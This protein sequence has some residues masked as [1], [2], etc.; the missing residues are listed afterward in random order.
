MLVFKQVTNQE[1]SF[2]ILIQVLLRIDQYYCR[3]SV[4]E[5]SRCFYK[6]SFRGYFMSVTQN[7]HRFVRTIKTIKIFEGFPVLRS[8]VMY[9]LCML[10]R[11]CWLFVN[12][13]QASFSCFVLSKELSWNTVLP[14]MIVSGD[15]TTSKVITVGRT[16]RLNLN[17]F[18][19]S[20]SISKRNASVS[21]GVR[22]TEKEKS[23]D[24]VFYFSRS[25]EPPMKHE[26][27]LFDI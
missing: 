13:S 6:C 17:S 23:N 26:A 19:F 27:R 18:W 25:L 2:S 3:R 24:R 11:D 7:G 12:I 20:R 5:S 22:N 16:L 15:L 14:E 9:A 21:W 4:L 10:H 1:K 8:F